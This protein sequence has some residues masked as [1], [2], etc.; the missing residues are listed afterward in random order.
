MLVTRASMI[1]R[2]D[3]D[4]SGRRMANGRGCNNQQLMGKRQRL[5]VVAGNKSERTVAGDERQKETV[6]M[7]KSVDTRTTARDDESRQRTMEQMEDNEAGM[8]GTT[9]HWR[10]IS[11]DKWLAMRARGQWVAMG[12][13]R[14]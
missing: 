5:A 10:K 11:K 13:K 6:A 12:S 8:D 1:A 2:A 14:G 9:N 4:K 7:D 3:H